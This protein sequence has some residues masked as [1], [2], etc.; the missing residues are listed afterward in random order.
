[1]FF[2][3]WG[4]QGKIAQVGDSQIMSCSNC[5]VDTYWTTMV[6]YTVRHIYWLFRWTTGRTLYRMCGNCHGVEYLEN[7]AVGPK[8]VKAA[9]PFMDRNGWTIGAGIIAS[10]FGLGTIA[11]AQDVSENRAILQTPRAGDIYEVDLAR[12][13]DRP[14]APV[15]YSAIRVVD[16]NRDS[17]EVQ[18]ADLYYTERQGVDRDVLDG[19]AKNAGYYR[20]ERL[21]LDK[22]ALNRMQAD[23]VIFDV[24]R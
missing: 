17:V 4:K 14:E 10:L 2:I 13:T 12:M 23:G 6:E 24:E 3:S 5:Q 15:M 20:P 16:V 19:K 18:L 21:K 22:A 9:I 7:K 8:A 11:A 1:M